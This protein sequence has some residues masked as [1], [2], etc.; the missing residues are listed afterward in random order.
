MRPRRR[1]LIIDSNR[2]RAGVLRFTIET[3]RQYTARIAAT[4][5]EARE[6]EAEFGPDLVIAAPSSFD[7]LDALKELRD[8][9]YPV[10]TMLIAP[11]MVPEHLAMYADAAFVNPTPNEIFERAHILCMRKRGPRKK[12]VQAEQPSALSLQPTAGSVA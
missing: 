7:L 10:P 8:R 1:V 6:I 4:A 2:N 5:A 12:P 11:R 9:P 3:M